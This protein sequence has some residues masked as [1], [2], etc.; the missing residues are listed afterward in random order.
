MSFNTCKLLF[1]F[2]LLSEPTFQSLPAYMYLWHSY[3]Y[4]LGHYL[5]IIWE[6]ASLATTAIRVGCY[7]P[8]MPAKLSSSQPYK[9][10]SGKDWDSQ[11]SWCLLSSYGNNIPGSN[12]NHATHT[13][14]QQHMKNRQVAEMLTVYTQVQMVISK[15]V[16]GSASYGILVLTGV[17]PF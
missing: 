7:W 10:A 17:P 9:H 11:C 5:D 13:A 2:Y 6:H 8:I 14:S 1:N 4:C 16:S 12:G 3:Q 15:R